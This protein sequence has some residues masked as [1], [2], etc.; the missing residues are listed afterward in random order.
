MILAIQTIEN[1]DE[2]AIYKYGF[3]Y[4]TY[5]IHIDIYICPLLDKHKMKYIFMWCRMIVLVLRSL[6]HVSS[7]CSQWFFFN[8]S[9]WYCREQ[10]I[11]LVF[12][13]VVQRGAPRKERQY[14]FQLGVSRLNRNAGW[15]A[16]CGSGCFRSGGR[17]Y[18]QKKCYWLNYE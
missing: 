15:S 1:Q 18:F 17:K 14:V 3:T 5:F 13:S 4:S 10:A 7:E 6:C 12:A 16:V 9:R 2:Y 8:I 11:N